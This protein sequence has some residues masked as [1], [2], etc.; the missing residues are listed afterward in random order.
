MEKII[1][2]PE[3][4]DVQIHEKTVKVIGKNGEIE[5]TFKHFFDITIKK[6]QKIENIYKHYSLLLNE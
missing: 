2:I 6:E 1:N 5:R 3:D 4:V